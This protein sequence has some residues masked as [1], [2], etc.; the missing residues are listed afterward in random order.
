M[1]TTAYVR[2]MAAYNATMNQRVY[3]AAARLSDADRRLD[4]GAFWHSI[5]ETLSHL[6]WADRSW[7]ARFAGWAAPPA[8]LAKGADL[9]VHFDDM[10]AARA[11][12]DAKISAWASTLGEEWLA[13]DQTWMSGAAGRKVTMPRPLLVAH[14]FNHQTHHRGQVHAMLTAAGEDTGATDL[15]WVLSAG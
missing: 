7:M 11:D 5:H 8:P 1:I 12:D 6:I 10:S 15:P 2:T 3:A 13:A 14:M 9:F 4:R